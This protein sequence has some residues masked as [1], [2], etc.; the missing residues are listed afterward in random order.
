VIVEDDVDA[1]VTALLALPPAERIKAHEY[2]YGHTNAAV[3]RFI[4]LVVSDPASAED[5]RDALDAFCRLYAFM[6]QVMPFSDI[7]LEKY[8][9]YGRLLER[10]LPRRDSGYVD[11]G[12][13]D[14]TYLRIRDTGVFDVSLGEEGDQQL[15]GFSTGRGREHDSRKAMTRI[16]EIP[17][18]RSS[19]LPT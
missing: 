1:F 15:P 10:R 18:S 5:F 17:H 11:V 4:E 3:E 12:D 8:Y 2:L 6:A 9:L 19:K 7:D 14:M 13:L 16:P